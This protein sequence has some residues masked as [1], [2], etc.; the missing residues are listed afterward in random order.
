MKN[1]VTAERLNDLLDGLLSEIEAASVRAH[2]GSCA[3]CSRAHEGLAELLGDL[4]G[5]P[6]AATPPVDLWPAI[7]ERMAGVAG[8]RSD[9]GATVLTFPARVGARRTRSVSLPSAAAAAILLSVLSAGTVWWSMAGA[10]PPVPETAPPV[11]DA[12]GSTALLAASGS[13]EYEQAVARRADLIDRGR[14]VLAPE[15]L[16]T[17][18]ASLQTVEQALAEVRAALA[19]DPS[20]EILASMLVSHQRSKL[21]LLRQAALSI[22]AA[23]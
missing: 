20:S 11:A 10:G 7:E 14:G 18:D 1:H 4:H 9:G 8:G 6:D 16:E 3:A 5:L 15:T 2:L 21:R 12:A 22:Q 13:A 19:A 23:S 17:L